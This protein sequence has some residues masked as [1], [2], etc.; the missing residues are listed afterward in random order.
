[1]TSRRWCRSRLAR[2]CFQVW[3]RGRTGDWII[4]GSAIG[5]ATATKYTAALMVIMLGTSAVLFIARTRH[6]R[7][8]ATGLLLSGLAIAGAYFALNPYALIDFSESWSEL[9]EQSRLSG[10][11]KPG[12]GGSA[13]SHYIWSLTW[14]LGWLPLVSAGAGAVLLLWRAPQ[15]ALLLLSFPLPLF[16]FLSLQG[17]YFG[18]WLL[19]IYP[20]RRLRRVWSCARGTSADRKAFT[21]EGGGHRGNSLAS[22]C[23]GPEIEHARR[24]CSRSSGHSRRTAGMA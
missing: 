10:Q 18:R 11:S 15:K 2:S 21:L 8:A 20:A 1:M 5:V 4:A 23:P 9:T 7:Q 16:V 12:Q 22:L 17:R 24:R 13:L 6:V 14:G 19:P 3:Q